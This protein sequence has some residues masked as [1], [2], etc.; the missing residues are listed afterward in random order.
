[1]RTVFILTLILGLLIPITAQQVLQTSVFGNGGGIA[2][3]ASFHVIST[4]GQTGVG[5]SV[6]ANYTSYSGF[7]FSA[8]QI[9]A[10]EKDELG[11]PDK[12]DLQQNYPNPFNPS[13]TIKY[14]IPEQST[15]KLVIFN[16]LGELVTELVNQEQDIGYYEVKLN[17]GNISSGVYFYRLQVYTP[18]RAGDFIKTKKMVLLK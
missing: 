5:I 3:N 6:N 13:T 10:V 1:M 9:T 7:W 4:L 12:F 14:S 8:D 15:V 11:L 2:D 17:A 16:M 18:G